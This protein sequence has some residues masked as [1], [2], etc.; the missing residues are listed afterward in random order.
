MLR[1]DRG[2]APHQGRRAVIPVCLSRVATGSVFH[3]VSTLEPIRGI[4]KTFLEF[5]GSEALPPVRPHQSNSLTRRTK[6]PPRVCYRRP[7][8]RADRF[9]VKEN[10][11][12]PLPVIDAIG[13]AA[14]SLVLVT[15]C[16]RFDV[17]VALDRDRQ[18]SGFHRLRLSRQSRA[19]AAAARAAARSTAGGLRSCIACAPTRGARTSSRPPVCLSSWVHVATRLTRAG[20]RAVPAGAGALV[21]G[22]VPPCVPR[23]P[24]TLGEMS[25]MP[26]RRFLSARE[27]WSG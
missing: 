12:S 18:Q 6:R 3:P 10:R 15:F 16:M 27:G 1:A 26:I 20:I 9:S 25:Q 22:F 8:V 13:F 23:R 11:M 24:M 4:S 19:G 2:H 5:C 17:R 7:R 21:G 14:A